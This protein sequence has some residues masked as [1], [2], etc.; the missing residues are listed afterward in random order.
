MAIDFGKL[1]STKTKQEMN[2]EAAERVFFRC[3]DDDALAHLAMYYLSNSR[4][5]GLA[6]GRGHYDGAV[7]HVILPELL[8]RTAARG[9]A[10]LCAACGETHATPVPAEGVQWLRSPLCTRA[11][12]GLPHAHD[13]APAP[14]ALA[15]ALA[16]IKVGYTGQWVVKP[17]K[18]AW[19]VRSTA[20]VQAM[21]A[22]NVA[23]LVPFSPPYPDV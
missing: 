9:P 11:Q 19:S 4:Q 12:G 2:H 23:W 13:E 20:D 18:H 16:L 21:Q 10:G 5:D 1:L 14:V 8:R 6:A 15:D 22:G 3:L 7:R 17:T